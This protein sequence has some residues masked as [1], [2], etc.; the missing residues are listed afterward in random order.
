MYKKKKKRKIRYIN[1]IFFKSFKFYINT[2]LKLSR[3]I[4]YIIEKIFIL[5]NN[6]IIHFL[7]ITPC[8]IEI[9]P[10]FDHQI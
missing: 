3:S 4:K 5:F 2:K 7:T 9:Y 8:Q 1:K 10:Q 6:F